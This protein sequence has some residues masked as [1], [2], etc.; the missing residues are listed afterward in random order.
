[1]TSP[2]D[3]LHGSGDEEIDRHLGGFRQDLAELEVLHEA[4]DE[5]RGRGVAAQGRVVAEASPTGAFTGLTI[6]PRAMRLGSDELATV[7]L[8][9]AGAATRDA[10]SRMRELM[11]PL[12]AGTMLETAADD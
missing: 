5:V 12:V 8:Q 6:D 1:M 4:I 2:V 10:E 7:I 3:A 11:H 9:A